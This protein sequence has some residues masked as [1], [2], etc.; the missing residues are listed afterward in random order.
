MTLVDTN[1]LVDILS[2]DPN[3]RIW[4]VDRLE[5]RSSQG[6][7]LINDVIYAELSSRYSTE[8]LLDGKILELNV[9]LQR[10]AEA[11]AFHRG[12]RI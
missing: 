10:N 9:A 5:E 6:P 8:E 1:V 3:W 12:T 2:D 11:C 4:S 7:L